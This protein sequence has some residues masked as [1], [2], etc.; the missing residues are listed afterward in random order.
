MLKPV[1]VMAIIGAIFISVCMMFIKG[2]GD[3]DGN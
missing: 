3:I 1:L 2:R